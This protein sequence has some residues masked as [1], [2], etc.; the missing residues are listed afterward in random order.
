MKT[1]LVA[2]IVVCGLFSSHATAQATPIEAVQTCL[3][4]S[5]SGKDRK[6]LAKWIFLAMAAHPELK[7]LSTI[8]AQLQEDTSREFADLVMRLITV[9]CRIQMQTLT[10][11][12]ADASAS[13]KLAFSHLGQVAM[14]ELMTNKDVDASVSQFGDFLDEKELSSVLGK[15][16]GE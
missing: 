1:L 13:M 12:D 14:L 8:S 4:D 2:A 10:A 6:L 9:D 11:A 3:T 15:K 5:T 7:S 16:T